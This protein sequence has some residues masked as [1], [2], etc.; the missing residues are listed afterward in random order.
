MRELWLK[1]DPSLS[2]E[3][4]SNIV[5]AT[6]KYCDGYVIVGEDAD[7]VREIWRGKLASKHGGDVV[8]VDS[9]Q[10]VVEAKNKG[11]E[12]MALIDLKSP[13]DLKVVS[14]YVESS[15]DYIA[16]KCEDWKVIPVENLIAHTRGKAKLLAFVSSVEETKLMLETLELGVDGV[17]VEGASA[18]AVG[19]IYQV[20]KSTRT[21]V[22]ELEE[23]EKIRLTV[24]KIVGTKQLGSGARVC[25]DTCELMRE[26]E[27]MLVGCQSSGLFLVQAEVQETPYVASRPFR[28]N[29]GPVAQYILAPGNK[30]RYLSE[31]KSGEEVLIVDREGRVRSA[32]VCRVKIEWRPM[33]LIEAEHE[34]RRLKVILQNA[35]TIRVVTPEGSKSVTDLTEGDE[36]LL[37]VQKGGRHFGM[38]VEEERVIEA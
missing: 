5:K 11:K 13:E 17:V 34:G 12:A 28:V 16:V 21:R 35:E 33:M 31:L 24:A 19:P 8:L 9:P 20:V 10:E 23:A 30:T 36:V 4:K 1:V 22:D 25:V 29:A 15:C 14:E 32:N 6:T 18:E 38:L 37:Y 26:G 7:L 27:G 3:A 2:S